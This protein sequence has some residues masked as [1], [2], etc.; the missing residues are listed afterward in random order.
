MVARLSVSGITSL[1][2]GPTVSSA[3]AGTIVFLSKPG[4][5]SVQWLA[6]RSSFDVSSAPDIPPVAE[7][8]SFDCNRILKER[9][10]K[11]DPLSFLPHKLPIVSKTTPLVDIQSIKIYF[12][13]R[14]KSIMEDVENMTYVL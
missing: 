10:I 13:N 8:V 9:E 11:H 14:I 4:A 7:A 3:S 6:S 12:D 2:S 1:A 5:G